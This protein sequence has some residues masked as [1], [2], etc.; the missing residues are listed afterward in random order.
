MKFFE[1]VKKVFNFLLDCLFPRCCIICNKKVDGADYYNLCSSC[2]VKI[3]WITGNKCSLCSRPM[4]DTEVTSGEKPICIECKASPPNFKSSMS[5][6]LHTGVG[7]DIILTLK[8]RNADFLKND[9]AT[10]LKNYCSEVREFVANSLLV[11]VPIHYF[12]RVKRG[13]NQT[14]I[15]A[16]AIAK[17]VD[18]ATVIDILKSK[19]KKSQTK[20]K[21]NERLLNIKDMFECSI[22]SGDIPQDSKIVIVDDVLTTGSTLNECCRI[23]QGAGFSNLHVLT[24][25]YG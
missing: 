15:I 20:L 1:K 8:Y 12:R 22:N 19:N 16:H 17:I 25:S 23:L 6:W 3:Q 9:I 24:L 18:S 5:C 14:E 2:I 11:P 7:R 10:L 4:G 13:Y 21:Y